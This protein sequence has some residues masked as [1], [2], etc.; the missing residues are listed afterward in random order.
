MIYNKKATWLFKKLLLFVIML[1]AN[2]NLTVQSEIK[3]D[4]V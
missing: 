3:E 2:T 1:T 4:E